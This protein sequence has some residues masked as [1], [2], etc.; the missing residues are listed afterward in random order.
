LI[1]T[2]VCVFLVLHY[3]ILTKDVPAIGDDMNSSQKTPGNEYIKIPIER[4]LSV[5]SETKLTD[6][7]KVAI[8]QKA[9]WERAWAE[10]ALPPW[11][12]GNVSPKDLAQALAAYHQLA[13]TK[14]REKVHPTHVAPEGPTLIIYNYHEEPLN[15]KNAAFF[16]RHHKPEW[17]DVLLVVNGIDHSL[18]LPSWVHVLLRENLGMEFCAMMEILPLLLYGN[19][20]SRDRNLMDLFRNKYSHFV[21]LN[22]SVRGPFYPL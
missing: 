11:R 17:A 20:T 12:W 19:P 4:I 15:K 7:L 1:W 6:K 18:E 9:K 22:A 14:K 8:N 3:E 5:Y 10:F 2:V 13:S 16:F 21:L